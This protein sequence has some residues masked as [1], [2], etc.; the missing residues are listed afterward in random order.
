MRGALLTG[1]IFCFDPSERA[2]TDST[3][4]TPDAANAPDDRPKIQEPRLWSGD[5]WTAR[6]IK[7]EDD[8]GWAGAALTEGQP[9]PAAGGA[10]GKGGRAVTGKLDSFLGGRVLMEQPFVKDGS[11]SIKNLIDSAVQ[12]FGEKVEIVRYERL[13]VR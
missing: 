6:V 11:V 8:D 7:N 10:K 13:S 3:P 2:L 9:A 12:K 4:F 5:G 1:A